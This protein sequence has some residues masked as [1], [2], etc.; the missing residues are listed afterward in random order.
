M[1]SRDLTVLSVMFSAGW[2]EREVQAHP[3]KRGHRDLSG[4]ALGVCEKEMEEEEEEEKG[5]SRKRGGG[6]GGR[7]REREEEEGMRKH[8]WRS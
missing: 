4:S 7:R 6:E 2:K 1:D 3:S 5:R 8:L